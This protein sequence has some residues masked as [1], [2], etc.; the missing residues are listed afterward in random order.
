MFTSS[1]NNVPDIVK[2]A[3]E[4]KL[5]IVEKTGRMQCPHGCDHGKK[6][7]NYGCAVDLATS[8]WCCHL[9]REHHKGNS[10]TLIKMFGLNKEDLPYT[11]P[12][13]YISQKTKNSPLN[14]EIA[15]EDLQT[16][17]D[18]EVIKKNWAVE[19][20]GFSADIGEIISHFTEITNTGL[21]T[22][23]GDAQKIFNL[24]KG[25]GRSLLFSIMDPEGNISSMKRCWPE[26]GFPKDGG[27]K[28]K[29][30]PGYMCPEKAQ[31]TPRLFGH[32]PQALSE[33]GNS[34]LYIVEGAPD[35]AVAKAVLIKF[36]GKAPVVGADSVHDLPKIAKVLAKE[37][38]DKLV[39]PTVVIIPHRGDTRNIGEEK[40]KEAA[41]ILRKSTEV[42]FVELPTELGEKADLAD[43]LRELGAE[44]TIQALSNPQIPMGLVQSNTREK[45]FEAVE[46]F[47]NQAAA[48]LEAVFTKAIENPDEVPIICT[49]PGAGKSTTAREILIK[50]IS[51]VKVPGRT[52][53][54]QGVVQEELLTVVY[55]APT[56]ELIEE[57]IKYFTDRG[58]KVYATIGRQRL[59][60]EGGCYN[61]EQCEI[62]EMIGCSASKTCY[63]CDMGPENKS[64]TYC[65]YYTRLFN[66][67]DAE[68]GSIILMTT[69]QWVALHH[70]RMTVKH[71]KKA[72][73]V[74]RNV[75]LAIF[76]EC[77]EDG[78]APTKTIYRDLEPSQK[79]G[80]GS[81]IH[82]NNWPEPARFLGEL[83]HEMMSPAPGDQL[84]K[85]AKSL[86]DWFDSTKFQGIQGTELRKIIISIGINRGKTREELH[87]ILAQVK[88]LKSGDNRDKSDKTPTECSLPDWMIRFAELLLDKPHRLTMERLPKKNKT[89][90]RGVMTIQE[91]N[92]VRPYREIGNHPN[93]KENPQTAKVPCVVFDAYGD[94]QYKDW[95]RFFP[96][97]KIGLKKV[98][99]KAVKEKVSIYWLKYNTSRKALG[100]ENKFKKVMDELEYSI[101]KIGLSWVIYTH[102]ANVE[103]VERELEKRFK[104]CPEITI[105]VDYYGR[106]KGIN[107]HKGKNIALFGEARKNERAIAANIYAQTGRKPIEAQIKKQSRKERNQTLKEAVYR[108]RPLD[109][110]EEGLTVLVFSQ[111]KPP[112]DLIYGVNMETGQKHRQ[113]SL[114]ELL[115]Q[116]IDE[117]GWIPSYNFL[118]GKFSENRSYS[119]KLPGP[120]NIPFIGTGQFVEI[121]KK[122]PRER[123][124]KVFSEVTAG[125]K[126]VRLDGFGF[127]F[128]NPNFKPNCETDVTPD[129]AVDADFETKS[130]YV[131]N[132]VCK[133]LNL[134]PPKWV[135][136][137]FTNLAEKSNKVN[138]LEVSHKDDIP[139][140]PEVVDSVSS[141]D[142]A[143]EILCGTS[144]LSQVFQNDVKK[145]GS[146]SADFLFESVRSSSRVF[147]VA[148][149]IF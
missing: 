145:C 143:L 62:A 72:S 46:E 21:F 114:A 105:T 85:A 113:Q 13:K 36:T 117:S 125:M 111:D 19:A 56:H 89:Q 6:R 70:L 30:L 48:W 87:E 90:P 83:L 51:E 24:S 110:P 133:S 119:N 22:P 82:R 130:A 127:V 139:S 122:T 4:L 84:T 135:L 20:R 115:R 67:A 128:I 109:A 14:L 15:W 96:D 142:I 73:S 17:S 149:L 45:V 39:P 102:K 40:A 37:F 107:T 92:Q 146:G 42:R 71:G 11:L 41:E 79:L 103:K 23:E 147:S 80:A 44:A 38:E 16:L 66:A 118:A 132:L 18:P 124:K 50:F 58:Q 35:F 28:T 3:K 2:V 141:L 25:D 116:N 68:P 57:A 137:I 108:C 94:S 93:D 27:P 1:A 64:G 123:C 61:P 98:Q 32:L 9:D 120:Y 100:D 88:E 101:K 97:R 140:V 47:R 43:C 29:A 91:F 12:E 77:P 60:G 129:I 69:A 49:T 106:A 8:Q 121:L 33:A 74:L 65:E 78:H 144:N 99:I 86:E 55:I 131:V 59:R 52:T 7:A 75:G 10:W 5:D 112:A 63:A 81:L 95:S 138:G 53:S 54:T 136:R 26:K 126:R 148:P 104:E 34:T 134:N 31:G 76:D